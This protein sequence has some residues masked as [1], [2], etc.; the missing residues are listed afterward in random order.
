M[1]CN[2]VITRNVCHCLIVTQMSRQSRNKKAVATIP[3]RLRG[4]I[5]SVVEIVEAVN[6]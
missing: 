4:A 3:A 2:R 6:S 5:C 1:G